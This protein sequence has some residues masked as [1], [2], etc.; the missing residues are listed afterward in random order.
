MPFLQEQTDAAIAIPVRFEEHLRDGVKVA[1]PAVDTQALLTRYG[2]DASKPEA[3]IA[4][5]WRIVAGLAQDIRELNAT[6]GQ[7]MSVINDCSYVREA[8]QN[9]L[10]ERYELEL[11]ALREAN[12]PSD[13]DAIAAEL[14]TSDVP[15][16]ATKKNKRKG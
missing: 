12:L 7:V 13:E 11:E 9:A 1:V 8:V 2:I 3:L 16:G 14:S 10:N 4:V 5:L 6:A 15:A